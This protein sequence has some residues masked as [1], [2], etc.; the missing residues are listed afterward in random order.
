MTKVEVKSKEFILKCIEQCKQRKPDLET[1]DIHYQ[2]IIQL[3]GK[4]FELEEQLKEV[5]NEQFGIRFFS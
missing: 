2:I 4:V 3:V 5:K 1:S